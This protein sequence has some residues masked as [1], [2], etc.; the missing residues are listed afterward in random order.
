MDQ[1]SIDNILD[2]INDFQSKC[3]DIIVDA[4]KL[5]VTTNGE[6]LDFL[7]AR[8]EQKSLKPNQSAT[9]QFLTKIKVPT[10]FFFRCPTSIQQP[11]LDYFNVNRDYLLRCVEEDTCRAVLS[12]IF[13]LAYDNHK[14]FPVILDAL[15][16][17]DVNLKT[18]YNDGVVTRLEVLLANETL[19]EGRI[20]T[21]G[22]MVTN[23]ETG[24]SSLWIEPIVVVD[25]SWIFASRANI[26]AEYKHFRQIHKGEGINTEQVFETV[27]QVLQ[28]AQV[29]VIQ[30]MEGMNKE[31]KV[32]KAVDFAKSLDA[33]PKR[34]TEILEQE[35]RLEQSLKKEKAIRDILTAAADL[36]IL[37]KISIEQ[38]TGKWYEI[39]SHYMD[40][41]DRLNE[42]VKVLQTSNT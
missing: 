40:R 28:A 32:E 10:S 37:S 31:V 9:T 2:S 34:Y 21:P 27:R 38:Q 33:L 11:I 14:V 20:L 30:Y 19:F 36:P 35:W 39:F 41:F 17:Q 23:S 18:F 4:D 8:A 15:K 12:P 42:D 7:L 1:Q 26:C 5:K 25:N 13:T 16:D 24:H 22:L 6:G 29:G 3:Y